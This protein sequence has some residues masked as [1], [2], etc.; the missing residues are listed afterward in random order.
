M[1]QRV[2][3]LA[4]DGLP[5][6]VGNAEF[7]IFDDQQRKQFL[8]AIAE[9][10]VD[11]EQKNLRQQLVNELGQDEDFA[12]HIFAATDINAVEG[13]TAEFLA[14]KELRLTI[15]VI[16]FF[17]DLIPYN[18]AF[19]G[20]PGDAGSV[21]IAVLQLIIE[22][23]EKESLFI[24]RKR[25]GSLGQLSL[26][27]LQQEE[28]SKETGFAKASSF[29]KG[30]Q[31]K[32]QEQVIASLQWAGRATAEVRK[33][34]AF[35]LFAIALESIVLADGNLQELTYRLRGRVAHLL[36]KSLSDRKDISTTQCAISTTFVQRLCTVAITRSQ[37]N[38]WVQF[39]GLPRLS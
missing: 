38:V 5:S 3:G 17:A 7:V 32:L 10:N 15:D 22:G 13:G 23:S 27:K 31:N 24:N 9:H 30:P 29:L 12:N 19:L 25:I 35:L 14:C 20:L 11:E 1:Y 28:S 33:E 37:M 18:F 26:V 39:G 16:N 8:A 34:E 21:K 4:I 36:G 6:R 2:N